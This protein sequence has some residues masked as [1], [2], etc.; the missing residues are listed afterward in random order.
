MGIGRIANVAIGGI[1]KFVMG[2]DEQL[3]PLLFEVWETS[4]KAPES[5]TLYCIHSPCGDT[6]LVP[7]VID[8]LHQR[9]VL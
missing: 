8:G 5:Y 2:D 7:R 3:F 6:T 9:G 4:G 1:R